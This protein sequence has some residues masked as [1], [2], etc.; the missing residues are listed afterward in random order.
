MKLCSIASGSSGNCIYVGTE[1][2]S[3]LVDVG[4]SKKRIVEG[5]GQIGVCPSSIK[6][7][8]I[9]HEHSDHIKGLG[10]MSRQYKLPIFGTKETIEEIKRISSL[11]V[12]DEELFHEICPDKSCV[13]GDIEVSPFSSFHDARNPVC[14]TFSKGEH[15][16]GIATDLG[17][18]D[19]YIIKNLTGCE[20]L[21]L[22]AN[23]DVNMLQVG[24]YP[25]ALKRRVLGDLGHLSNDMSGRLLTKLIHRGL[26]TIFL[27]HLSKENNYPELAYET[28]KYELEKS[29]AL[30]HFDYH[31]EI[32]RR[33]EISPLV[34]TDYGYNLSGEVKAASSR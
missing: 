13:L 26:K 11:G 24:S 32:A 29:G 19:D 20:I 25:Y 1:K 27:G 2:T 30:E 21:L 4:I 8:L 9:T 14:Y 3:L 34:S 31:L 18:Y 12:I 33:D 5:L 17:T 6:G 23:H 7:I 28:V 10:V 16:V 22:E 15:K